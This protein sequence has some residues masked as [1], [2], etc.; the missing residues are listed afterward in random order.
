MC[1]L[2]KEQIAL[3]SGEAEEM[4]RSVQGWVGQGFEHPGLVEGPWQG[5]MRS[6]LRSVLTQTSL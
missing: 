5:G 1:Q 6:A 4:G 2:A 3:T